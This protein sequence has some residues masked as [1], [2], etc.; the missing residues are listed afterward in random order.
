MERRSLSRED[1]F[2][3][4]SRTW[5]DNVHG[6]R[7]VPGDRVVTPD[8]LRRL[9]PSSLP[10]QHSHRV[11]GIPTHPSRQARPGRTPDA[12]PRAPRSKARKSTIHSLLALF[13]S[14]NRPLDSRK[15][16]SYDNLMDLILSR[17]R[18]WRCA[19]TMNRLSCEAEPVSHTEVHVFMERGASRG[20]G[21]KDGA[22]RPASKHRATRGS[23]A[24]LRPASPTLTARIPPPTSGRGVRLRVAAYGGRDG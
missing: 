8:T 18:R 4:W 19:R 1:E 3:A 7:N 5:F 16:S 23:S 12:P 9:H 2:G 15:R 24:L 14:Q 13:P 22:C 10:V 20:M 21:T 11:C 6:T 17:Q